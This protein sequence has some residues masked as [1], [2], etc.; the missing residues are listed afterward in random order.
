MTW[1]MED[2][3]KNNFL[4]LNYR[5]V[6]CRVLP[7]H[8]FVSRLLYHCCCCYCYFCCCC[9]CR[10]RCDCCCC[11]CCSHSELRWWCS[12]LPL[13]CS[14]SPLPLSSGCD[15]LFYKI[16]NTPLSWSS[17]RKGCELNSW[18]DFELLYKY[19]FFFL[20]YYK[21]IYDL[22]NYNSKKLW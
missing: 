6:N 4:M 15:Q 21:I 5:R 18:L 22:V 13:L 8:R 12:P 11:R 17:G 16:W 20:H 9:C 2:R 10:Y 14:H 19:M 3:V 7:F 1:A